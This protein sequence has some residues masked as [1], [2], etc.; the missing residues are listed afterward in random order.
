MKR[1]FT[2]IE[3]LVVIA[4]IAILAAMLLPALNGSRKQAKSVQ[5]K[6]NLKQIGLAALGY[7]N[8]YDHYPAVYLVD[9]AGNRLKGHIT[10]LG[11]KY[12]SDGTRH[13]PN[14]SDI[15]MQLGYLPRSC[16]RQ[17]SSRF[18]ALDGV[19][20][21]PESVQEATSGI[22]GGRVFLSDDPNGTRAYYYGEMPTYVYNAITD[23]DVSRKGPGSGKNSGMKH[24]AIKYPSATMLFGDGCVV[25]IIDRYPDSCGVRISKRHN[26]ML[27]AVHCDGS[28]AQYKTA[29]YTTNRYLLYGGVNR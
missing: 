6:N 4:I 1:K 5:C 19:L 18:L 13:E 7:V 10:F 27:N 9:E 15:L 3:L 21:C 14:W 28:V 2:L 8:D 25:G 26:N 24:N 23:S 20:R 11:A 12:Y 22:N 16:G 17:V 29:F